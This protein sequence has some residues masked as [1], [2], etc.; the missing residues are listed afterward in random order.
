M[1]VEWESS[2]EASA[3]AQVG[4]DGSWRGIVTVEVVRR[5]QTYAR[6]AVWPGIC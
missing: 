6:C 4:D 2:V 3:V 5:G 1:Q